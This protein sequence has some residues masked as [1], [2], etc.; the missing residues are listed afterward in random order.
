MVLIAELSYTKK[1]NNHQCVIPSRN[2][3]PTK[4]NKK[5]HTSTAVTCYNQEN[6]RNNNRRSNS[7][8]TMRRLRLLEGKEEE[9]ETCVRRGA[10]ERLTPTATR[11]IH[12]RWN[13]DIRAERG[14][15]ERSAD[16]RRS[17]RGG[18]A[19]GNDERGRERGGGGS[20]KCAV[21]SRK[22]NE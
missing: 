10:T 2:K 20:C 7:E 9:R 12:P 5:F 4:W 17:V 14:V 6:A 19:M 13:R 1:V 18:E 8:L 11:S 16:L 21:A 15:A 3:D 22:A